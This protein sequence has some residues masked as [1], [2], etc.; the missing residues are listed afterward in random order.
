MFYILC[1]CNVRNLMFEQRFNNSSLL[2]FHISHAAPLLTVLFLACFSGNIVT[3]LY[4]SP[5]WHISFTQLGI[6]ADILE[7]LFK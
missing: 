5:W 7:H 4:L 2:I 3:V 6:Q 1:I